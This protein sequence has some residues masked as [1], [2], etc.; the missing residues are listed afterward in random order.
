MVFCGCNR[1][2]DSF[3]IFD[4]WAALKENLQDHPLTVE[5]KAY[6]QIKLSALQRYP[7]LFPTLELQN[8]MQSRI[9]VLLVLPYYLFCLR[10]LL[11]CHYP[12]DI[13][14]AS[15][16]LLSSRTMVTDFLIPGSLLSF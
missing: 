12:H 13:V 1:K 15:L 9:F 3:T 10:L 2:L 16:I 14:D 8:L 5:A 7:E 4:G 11:G 6:V